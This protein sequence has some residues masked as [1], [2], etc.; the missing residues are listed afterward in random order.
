MK[1]LHF[2]QFNAK[3]LEP[4]YF[5]EQGVHVDRNLF[6][7]RAANVV[8]VLE[9]VNRGRHQWAN[10]DQGRGPEHLVIGAHVRRGISSTRHESY[11]DRKDGRGHEERVH[12]HLVPL[13]GNL[14]NLQC[15]SLGQ[16]HVLDLSL[17]QVLGASTPTQYRFPTSRLMNQ[18]IKIGAISPTMVLKLDLQ[19]TRISSEGSSGFVLEGT[20]RSA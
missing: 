16:G 19:F 15:L 4:G 11:F 13:L 8:A 6:M 12:R 3:P 5:P 7:L 2:Y 1:C 10:I 14:Q 17:V 20:T 9:S 18:G